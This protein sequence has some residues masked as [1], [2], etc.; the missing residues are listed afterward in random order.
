[1]AKK[2]AN[3]PTREKILRAAT[4]LMWRQ[5]YSRTSPA[6]VMQASSVGQGSFYHHFP[7]KRSLGLA[8][9]EHLVSMTAIG[10]EEVFRRDLPPLERIRNWIDCF[11]HQYRPPCDRGCP[12]GKI[13]LEMAGED[14][15]FREVLGRG[16]AAIRAKL[17][18]SLQEASTLGQ[19]EPAVDPVGMAELLLAGMEGAVLLGQCDGDAGGMDR[20]VAQLN[21]LLDHRSTPGPPGA[22]TNT[23]S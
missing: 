6:Q 19:L 23:G 15:E 13:G 9:V 22:G 12:L 17:T 14:P 18:E 3:H 5:G 21:R 8:V 20:S 16:F 10:L 2:G 7:D 11:A 1:M 4:N